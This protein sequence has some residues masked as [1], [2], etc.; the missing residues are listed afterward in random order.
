M[1]ISI[2]V[3]LIEVR[4]MEF[5]IYIYICLLT[6]FD[7]SIQCFLHFLIL[8]ESNSNLIKI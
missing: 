3:I 6:L 2:Y 5:I 1:Q 7:V 8:L 4:V